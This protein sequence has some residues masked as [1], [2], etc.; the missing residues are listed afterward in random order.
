MNKKKKKD[1]TISR[2][3]AVI[4]GI[5]IG[6]NAR[7]HLYHLPAFLTSG[8]IPLWD[9]GI[10]DTEN[11]LSSKRGNPQKQHLEETILNNDWEELPADVAHH[12][13][14]LKATWTSSQGQ[15][16]DSPLRLLSNP[17]ANIL[18][19]DYRPPRP[20]LTS[21]PFRGIYEVKTTFIIILRQNFLFAV[22]QH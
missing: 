14:W 21:S 22:C 10:I 12:N 17:T 15:L 20:P 1:F 5:A 18:K 7:D 19:H 9:R 16:K 4:Y 6:G 13:R 3:P 11:T 8:L 2:W